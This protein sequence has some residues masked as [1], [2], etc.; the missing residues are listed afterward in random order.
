MLDPISL[1]TVKIVPIR[2]NPEPFMQGTGFF[3]SKDAEFAY[4]ATN[5]HIV[6]GGRSPLTP[7]LSPGSGNLPE[8]LQL[9]FHPRA[10]TGFNSGEILTLTVQINDSEGEAPRWR[11]HSVHGYAVDAVVIPIRLND[12][13]NAFF[14][15]LSECGLADLPFLKVMDDVFVVGYPW[16][17]TAG[18]EVLPLYKRGSVASEPT[19]LQ[20]GLPRFLIDCRTASGMS[21]SPVFAAAAAP[22][23]GVFVTP[24]ARR[25]GLLFGCVGLYSGRLNESDTGKGQRETAISEIGIVWQLPTI[26]EIGVNGRPGTPRSRF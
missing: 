3:I 17:L 25:P 18:S 7:R 24:G 26:H 14:T 6:T 1:L 12:L 20:A 10:G 19:I 2:S 13:R 23:G 21:G 11:E 4:L 8:S 22:N 15:T 5:W 9:T 16:G